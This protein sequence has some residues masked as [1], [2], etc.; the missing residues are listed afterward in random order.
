MA[1]LYSQLSSFAIIAGESTKHT[2]RKDSQRLSPTETP[3]MPF[4][5]RTKMIPPPIVAVLIIVGGCWLWTMAALLP[6]MLCGCHCE[7]T[8]EVTAVMMNVSQKAKGGLANG[9]YDISGTIYYEGEEAYSNYHHVDLHHDAIATASNFHTQGPDVCDAYA[10]ASNFHTENIG[11]T[12]PWPRLYHDVHLH[13]D[14]DDD[15]ATANKFHTETPGGPPTQKPDWARE[16]SKA[17]AKEWLRRWCRHKAPHGMVTEMKM[18]GKALWSSCGYELPESGQAYYHEPQ[19][20]GHIASATFG[21][22]ARCHK[23]GCPEAVEIYHLK[24]E[25]ANETRAKAT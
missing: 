1:M 4:D 17:M 21:L 14:D 22:L 24:F 8:A 9:L 12:C 10:N 18:V 5:P 15:D 20:Q 7:S 13:H 6:S 23:Q 2:I 16:L 11:G 3:L 19:F 25:Y